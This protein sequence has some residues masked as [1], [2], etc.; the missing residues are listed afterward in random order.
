MGERPGDLI[1]HP[2][3][4]LVGGVRI[5]PRQDQGEFLAARAGRGVAIAHRV[6]KL[7]THALEHPV[8][9]GM[10]MAL[11][12]RLE[13][14]EVEGDQGD[15]LPLQCGPLQLAAQD[16]LEP[17]VV[18]ELGERVGLGEVAEL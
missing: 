5:G 15:S 14:V 1:P 4:D 11:I 7:G 18:R 10:P 9:E 12:D 6:A 13:V 17:S 16:L 3:G 8:A 2:L